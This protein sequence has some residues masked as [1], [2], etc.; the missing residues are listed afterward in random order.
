MPVQ[1]KEWREKRRMTRRE[2]SWLGLKHMQGI[3]FFGRCVIVEPFTF[4]ACRSIGHFVFDFE[5][6]TCA[7]FV[8]FF[9]VVI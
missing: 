2:V 6:W 5:H 9:R 1:M 4:L 7:L 8:E 3:W